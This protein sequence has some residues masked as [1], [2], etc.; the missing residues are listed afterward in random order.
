MLQT[1]L[2]RPAGPWTREHERV[3]QSLLARYDQLIRRS[4]S[5]PGWAGVP[6]E[7]DAEEGIQLLD[8]LRFCRLCAWLRLRE[9]ADRVGYSILIYQLTDEDIRRALFGP[10]AELRADISSPP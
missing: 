3:Y 2:V 9:P 7:E 5:S 1:L 4:E 6:F 8:A 10:P